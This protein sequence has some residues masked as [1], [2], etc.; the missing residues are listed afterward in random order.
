MIAT[1]VGF[2]DNLAL[3]K[4]SL[5]KTKLSQFPNQLIHKLIRTWHKQN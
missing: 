4:Y 3:M 5:T 1:I 2:F